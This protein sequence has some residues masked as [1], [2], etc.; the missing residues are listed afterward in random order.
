MYSLHS[1]K[2]EHGRLIVVISIHVLTVFHID[3]FS[4]SFLFNQGKYYFISLAVFLKFLTATP[5]F[6]AIKGN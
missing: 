3:D 2:N 1:R 6:G 5:C 4:Q